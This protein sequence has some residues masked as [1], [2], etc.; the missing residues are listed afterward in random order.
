MQKT[1]IIFCDCVTVRVHGGQTRG[2]LQ[3]LLAPMW[4][5][6]PGSEYGWLSG[7]EMLPWAHKHC[8]GA[9]P[10]ACRFLLPAALS[11]WSAHS[12]PSVSLGPLQGP[13]VAPKGFFSPLTTEDRGRPEAKEVVPQPSFPWHSESPGGSLYPRPGQDYTVGSVAFSLP[14]A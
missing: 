5:T 14:A 1:E 13:L 12:A 11:L 2:S 8:T 4:A 10:S 6:L 7:P 3:C 9:S